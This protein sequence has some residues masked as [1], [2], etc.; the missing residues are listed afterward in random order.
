MTVQRWRDE[1]EGDNVV[2]LY[3]TNREV[4][5]RNT[6]CLQKLNKPIVKIEAEHTGNGRSASSNIAG[7]LESRAFFCIGVFCIGAKLLLTKNVWQSAGLCNGAT[8]IIKDIVYD[9]DKNAPNLPD[10][11]LLDFGDSYAGPPFFLDTRY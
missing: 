7:G 10:Y 6:Q 1:F 2:H 11:I 5:M 3:C 9:P 8:G 4:A